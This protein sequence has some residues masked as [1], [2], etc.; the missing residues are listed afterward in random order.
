MRKLLAFFGIFNK[1]ENERPKCMYGGPEMYFRNIENQESK[2]D[3][4]TNN[5]NNNN[6][7]QDSNLDDDQK[8][9]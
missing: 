1:K 2:N 9:N 7:K 6:F 8:D 5:S 4:K 3:D